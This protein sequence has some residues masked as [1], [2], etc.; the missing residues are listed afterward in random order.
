MAG[1]GEGEDEEGPLT[2]TAVIR[3]TEICSGGA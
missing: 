3:Q 2:V 1:E